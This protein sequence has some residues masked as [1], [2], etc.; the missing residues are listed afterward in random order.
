MKSKI[1]NTFF[2]ELYTS[3]VLILSP[4]PD[5]F[6]KKILFKLFAKRTQTRRPVS[7][8]HSISIFK[9]FFSAF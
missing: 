3:C 5:S 8:N 6:D 4:K 2:L 1:S 9:L 7:F